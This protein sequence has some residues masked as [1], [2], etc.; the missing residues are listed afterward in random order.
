MKNRH[1]NSPIPLPVAQRRIQ[2][3]HCCLHHL[4]PSRHNKITGLT[5]LELGVVRA[6]EL[7]GLGHAGH[8]GRRRPDLRR[9][10]LE[11]IAHCARREGKKKKKKNVASFNATPSCASRKV[12]PD[13]ADPMREMTQIPGEDGGGKGNRRAIKQQD[14]SGREEKKGSAVGW[15]GWVGGRAEGNEWR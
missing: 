11:G 8:T 12:S 4:H 10:V 6:E 15:S 2:P 5:L 9:E 1:N 3:Q 14:A 13:R 7:E